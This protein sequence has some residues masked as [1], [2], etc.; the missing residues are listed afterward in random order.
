MSTEPTETDTT[1]S[2]ATTSD[3]E[4]TSTAYLW[5]GGPFGALGQFGP[6]GPLGPYGPVRWVRP[7]IKTGYE[8]FKDSMEGEFGVLGPK[9]PLGPLGPLGPGGP[10]GPLALGP[11]ASPHIDI[12]RE[13]EYRA[14]LDGTSY[15]VGSVATAE[16][17]TVY[18]HGDDFEDIY[19]IKLDQKDTITIVLTQYDV[20]RPFDLILLDTAGETV[21]GSTDYPGQVKYL[22]E[23]LPAGRYRIGISLVDGRVLSPTGE[24]EYAMSLLMR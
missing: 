17:G 21:A 12:L 9:G 6:L 10:L 24:S 18:D 16:Q 1:A 3:T 20:T 11:V 15:I 7:V 5:S 2:D 14:Y 13:E 22:E 8:V 23:T 4:L 19:D